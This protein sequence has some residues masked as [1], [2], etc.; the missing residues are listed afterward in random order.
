MKR[1]FISNDFEF[2]I[3]SM[4]V[5]TKTP[6]PTKVK[7][8]TKCRKSP[9]TRRA[10]TKIPVP[11]NRVTEVQNSSEYSKED[12]SLPTRTVKLFTVEHS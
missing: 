6:T 3:S 2:E 5:N 1:K 10:Y 11:P 12:I 4:K 7:V 9:V 8:K